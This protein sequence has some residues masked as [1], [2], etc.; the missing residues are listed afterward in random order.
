MLNIFN[1]EIKIGTQTYDRNAK[2]IYLRS[3][4]FPEDISELKKLSKFRNLKIVQCSHCKLTNEGLRI[5]ISN[6]QQLEKLNIL[7]NNITGT[8]LEYVAELKYLKSLSANYSPDTFEGYNHLRSLE[9]L[10]SLFLD[11]SEED[12]RNL[13][14][15]S[16]FQ[17]LKNLNLTGQKINGEGLANV[18]SLKL[19]KF[20]NLVVNEELNKDLGCLSNLKNLKGLSIS[21]CELNDKG[22]E[23]LAPLNQIDN[24]NLQWTQITNEGLRHLKNW[25]EIKWLRLK[26][27]EQL[28][29]NCVQHILAFINLEHL[30]IHETS[31]DQYGLEKLMALKHIEEIWIYKDQA[32]YEYDF[33][34]Q[35]SKKHPECTIQ[36]KSEGDFLN[37]EF[38]GVWR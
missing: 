23:N 27:N 6:A 20:L 38:E 17:G 36:L 18:G 19:L 4:T 33:L 9:N 8:A 21:S 7:G 16:N 31:I 2:S 5:L 13:K 26:E 14:V 3:D 30:G 35:L 32:I 12:N 37:G 29:N 24:L 1:K 22:L 15:I 25:K 28:D 10:D 34:I 11:I